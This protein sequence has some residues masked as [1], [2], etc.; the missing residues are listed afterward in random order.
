MIFFP[1]VL[2]NV[3]TKERL[4]QAILD[5]LFPHA[6]IIE[7]P[8]GCGKHTLTLSLSAALNCTAKNGSASLPCGCCDRCRRILKKNFVDVKYI[9]KK[10]GKSTIGVEDIRTMREDVYLSP[11][12]SEYKIYVIEDAHVMTTQAQNAL[13]KIFEEPPAGVVIFLLCDNIQQILS[14]IKSRAQLVRMQRLSDDAVLE[15]IS[16]EPAL[17]S[18][19]VSDPQALTAAIKLSQGSIGY[20][21]EMLSE[22]KGSVISEQRETAQEL[23]SSLI[24]GNGRFKLFSAIQSLP[25]KRNEFSRAAS[26]ILDGLRDLILVKYSENIELLFYTDIDAVISLSTRIGHV[27]LLRFYDAFSAARNKCEKNGNMSTIIAELG[28]FASRI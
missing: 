13:L 25:L 14:T 18:I 24:P 8:K 16:K 26:M 12:E 17:R 5:N 21:K 1:E 7:G 22:E 4:G 2:G 20:A 9:S 28:S 23:L 11:T 10:D 3:A 27:R 6:F 19:G 15:A